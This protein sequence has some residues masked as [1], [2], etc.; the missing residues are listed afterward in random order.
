MMATQHAQ[1]SHV[2]RELAS[3]QLDELA[4]AHEGLPWTAWREAV[5][6]WHLQAL[7]TAR[8]EAWVP[9]LMASYDPAVGKALSRFYDRHLRTAIHRLTH[10]NIE[11]RQKALAATECARFYASG[12]TDA[13]VRANAAL[14]TLLNYPATTACVDAKAGGTVEQLARRTS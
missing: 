11:L 1:I 4:L 12:A 10:E 3:T 2:E 5:I 6:E 9:G 13:G 8:A 7:T 14:R